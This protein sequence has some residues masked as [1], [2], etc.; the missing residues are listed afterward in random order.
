[1]WPTRETHPVV[2]CCSSPKQECCW[3]EPQVEVAGQDLAGCG[4]G[5]LLLALSP[6]PAGPAQLY[7]SCLC[8]A[9]PL[10]SPGPLSRAQIS[11]THSS[12]AIPSPLACGKLGGSGLCPGGVQS[13]ETPRRNSGDNANLCLPPSRQLWTR[14]GRC[15]LILPC[16]CQANHS[17][18]SA[19]SHVSLGSG[20]ALSPK[21]GEGTPRLSVPG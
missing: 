17:L 3:D 8:M 12:K 11:Q 9:E 14:Q 1:M 13:W 21:L 5:W 2:P 10:A 6:G 20:Q 18:R 4:L 7:L 15:G 16:S 19:Q